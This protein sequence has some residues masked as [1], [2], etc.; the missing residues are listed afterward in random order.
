MGVGNP[1]ALCMYMISI[2][3]TSILSGGVPQYAYGIYIGWN[4]Y[5]CTFGYNEYNFYFRI[6]TMT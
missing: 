6:A 5:L 2:Y 3:N 4:S 1:A